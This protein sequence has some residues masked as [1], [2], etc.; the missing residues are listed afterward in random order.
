MAELL[1]LRL[2]ELLSVGFE[3]DVYFNAGLRSIS[4]AVIQAL[5]NTLHCIQ[6][7]TSAHVGCT[8]LFFFLD[9]DRYSF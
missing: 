9:C 2:Y 6:D 5:V 3:C 1:L 4:R 8:T 7:T